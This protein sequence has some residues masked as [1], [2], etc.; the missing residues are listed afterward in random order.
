[1][2]A[3][4]PR[5]YEEKEKNVFASP[6]M[7]RN[8]HQKKVAFLAALFM[9]PT[10]KGELARKTNG[11]GRERLASA[12]VSLEPL[13]THSTS[14]REPRTSQA[15]QI[16]QSQRYTLDGR[17][18]PSSQPLHTSNI[19]APIQSNP[20]KKSSPISSPWPVNRERSILFPP[21]TPYP[22][23]FYGRYTKPH[24]TP[25]RLSHNP[26]QHTCKLHCLYI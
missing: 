15:E 22:N 8:R 20:A 7:F 23:V 19:P 17:T 25:F 10:E 1:M 4:L 16:S 2:P 3:Y 24:L 26:E 12:K 14:T 21:F 11:P 5:T 6:S 13:I 9:S 18:L